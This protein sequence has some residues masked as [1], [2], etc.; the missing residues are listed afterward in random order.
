MNIQILKNQSNKFIMTNLIKILAGT[1]LTFLLFSCGFPI[2]G[3][4]GEGKV[5]RK[6]KTIDQPFTAIEVS[7]GMEVV[8]SKSND[9]KV[10]VEANENLHDIIQVYVEGE[11]LHV[12]A[13]KNIYQADEKTVFVSYQKLTRLSGSS[14]SNVTSAEPIVQK[15]IKVSASSGANVNLQIRAENLNSHTSSGA[16]MKLTGQ[17]NVHSADASSGSNLRADE[18]L[19]LVTEAEGSSGASVKVHAKNEFTGKATSGASVSYYG[20]PEKVSENDSSGGSVRK[21]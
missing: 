15:E 13:D 7:R 10:I 11:T 3:V 21:K 19:S 5:V 6:E 17:V 2:D 1:F 4:R 20:N 16:A 14:G 12:T 9:K 8:L 18:L